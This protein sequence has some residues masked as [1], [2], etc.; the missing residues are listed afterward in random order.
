MKDAKSLEDS[1]FWV[2]YHLIALEYARDKMEG[3]AIVLESQNIKPQTPGELKNVIAKLRKNLTWYR[4]ITDS[5]IQSALSHI[6][7]DI[8][9]RAR[10]R[11]E[12]E[13]A[14][15]RREF[16]GKTD[17]VPRTEPSPFNSALTL[18]KDQKSGSGEG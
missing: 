4:G 3:E 8:L 6:P 2:A 18:K 16:L 15:Y 9:A 7:E 17:D 5:H 11:R 13:N 1:L 14:S 12:P 10:E